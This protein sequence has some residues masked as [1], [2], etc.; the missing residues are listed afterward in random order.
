MIVAMGSAIAI[1]WRRF[2]VEI[3]VEC[4]VRDRECT[5]RRTR[6][7]TPDR[8]HCQRGFFC[9]EEAGAYLEW[10]VWYAPE[11]AARYLDDQRAIEAPIGGEGIQVANTVGK[12]IALELEMAHPISERP[13][14]MFG[15][16]L[17]VCPPNQPSE[18][19]LRLR[20]EFIAR[21][22]RIAEGLEP[23]PPPRDG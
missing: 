7:A 18:S 8:P 17:S 16:L 13:R 14:D 10:T 9:K 4:L 20:E 21:W 5:V 3:A 1:E 12:W 15:A 22:T 6:W 11:L 2:R 23:I 19:D